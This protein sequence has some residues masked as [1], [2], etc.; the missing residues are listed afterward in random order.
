M[1][2][3]RASRSDVVPL[4]RQ[5]LIT[6]P[7]LSVPSQIGPEKERLTSL[8]LSL[9]APRLDG[10]RAFDSVDDRH[11]ELSNGLL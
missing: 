7:F 4:G 6:H 11:S 9:R 2:K 5:P 3:E 10:L 8:L 1:P